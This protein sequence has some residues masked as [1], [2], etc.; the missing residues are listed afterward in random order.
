MNVKSA[1]IAVVLTAVTLVNSGFSQS[2]G[3]SSSQSQT[4]PFS[5]APANVLAEYMLQPAILKLQLA[6]YVFKVVTAPLVV[7]QPA[8]PRLTPGDFEL[9]GGY[10]V[11]QVFS[12]PGLAIDFQTQRVYAGSRNN[13]QSINVYDLPAM[14]SG[15]DVSAWPRLTKVDVI[16]Q[17]WETV[18]STEATHPNGL[19]IRDGRLWVSPRGWYT[20]MPRPF[21]RIFGKSLS[22]GTVETKDIPVATQAYGGGFLKGHP[23]KWLIGAGGYMSGQ[24][25]VAGPTAA[26][27]DGEILLSQVDFGLLDFEAREKRPPTLSPV[28][29]VDTWQSMVPRG[30]VGAWGSDAA[31]AGGIWTDRGLCYWPRLHT[32]E[33]DYYSGGGKFSGPNETWLYTYD[34]FSFDGVQYQ[35]WSHGEVI[36]HELGEDGL[37]YL[38]INDA[39]QAGKYAVHDVIKVFRIIDS[40]G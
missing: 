7:D 2:L 23:S 10:I 20:I 37:V 33:A 31:I 32:G 11:P 35:K 22:N 26:T 15:D 19:E 13:E 38:L 29:G 8:G 12:N 9:M 3:G 24:G 28:S 27:A 6:N 40:E 25:G 18:P 34:P 16:P 30:D 21:L 5:Y 39:Y 14:G 36:G 17:F 4:S 1:L